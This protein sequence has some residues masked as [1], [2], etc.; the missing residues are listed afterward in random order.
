MKAEEVKQMFEDRHEA[1][2]NWMRLNGKDTDIDPLAQQLLSTRER[3]FT[4]IDECA[5][6]DLMMQRISKMA[7]DIDMVLP[8]WKE[9]LFERKQDD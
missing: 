4:L 7:T 1:F 5:D 9:F 6:D 8:N 2:F 3:T